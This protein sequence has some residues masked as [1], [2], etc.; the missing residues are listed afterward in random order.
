MEAVASIIIAL[1][2]LSALALTLMPMCS[3]E[4]AGHSCQH[5]PGDCDWGDR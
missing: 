5:R 2:T 3:R 1:A 4:R